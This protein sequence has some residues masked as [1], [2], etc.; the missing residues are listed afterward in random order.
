MSIVLVSANDSNKCVNPKI[1]LM[2]I[3]K[4]NHWLTKIYEYTCKIRKFKKYV[5]PS[6]VLYIKNDV[7]EPNNDFALQDHLLN[8]SRIRFIGYRSPGRAGIIYSS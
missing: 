1:N 4:M 3:I 8:F 2:D 5:E 7:T 6:N